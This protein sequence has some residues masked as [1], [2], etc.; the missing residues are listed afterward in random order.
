[1]LRPRPDEV[2][3]NVFTYCLGE[4]AARFGID[5]MMTAAES[6]H[7]HT[8]IFDRHGNVIPF[9]ERFHKHVA[10]AQNAHRG[11]WENL[12][13]SEPP[14]IVRLED[15]LAVIDAIVYTALNPVKDGL[16]ARVRDWPGVNGLVP[17][18]EARALRADRPTHFFR[19][20]GPMPE[21]V[22]LEMV[23]P[24]ELGDPAEIRTQ[25]RTRVEAAESRLA[26]ER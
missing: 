21:S 11:R 14:C 5:V 1:M 9:V 15:P 6:N 22:E 16:V 18:L 20:E 4:A 3:N 25:I 23:I 2:T 7:H 26:E 17:L 8:D 19:P 24:S 10:K 13:S 12:W